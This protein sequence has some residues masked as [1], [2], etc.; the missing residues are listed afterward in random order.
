MAER[1]A[2]AVSG[3]GQGASAGAT[4]GAAIG[5]PAGAAVG[6]VIGAVVGGIGGLLGGQEAKRQRIYQQR[7]NQTQ[8]TLS[9]FDAAVQ[10]RDMARSFLMTRG[11]SLAAITAGGEGGMLSSAPMGALS[12]MTSQYG[13]NLRYF[14]AR[15]RD[16]VQMQHYVDKAG[17][18]QANQQNIQGIMGGL[19]EATTGIAKAWPKPTPP[20]SPPPK[21]GTPA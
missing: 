10:R 2:G 21:T 6:A 4:L 20:T 12:S 3:A 5:G 14:D 18:K 9:L 1:E 11:E 17:Q 16:F 19:F 8:R 7:A 13:Q 15:I